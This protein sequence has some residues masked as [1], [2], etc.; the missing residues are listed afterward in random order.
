MTRFIVG[1]LPA[2]RVTVSDINQTALLLKGEGHGRRDHV[3]IYQGPQ[4][5]AVVKQQY[6]RHFAGAAPGLA[7]IRSYAG[8][9]SRADRT[10]SPYPG[11]YRRAP[12]RFERLSTN[13]VFR[14][15]GI[16][17]RAYQQN[18]R[19]GWA[20]NMLPWYAQELESNWEVMGRNF[21]SYCLEENR[22]VLETLFRYSLEQGLA[23][24]RLTVEG[25]LHHSGLK[26]SE[27]AR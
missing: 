9:P 11:R 3:F 14:H 16:F 7:G 17:I 20:S 26:L 6:K 15:K 24:K 8:A 23:S 1:K 27:Q 13:C 12:Y 18:A 2:E 25:L 5:S 21:F 4:L 22:K 10:L 19:L